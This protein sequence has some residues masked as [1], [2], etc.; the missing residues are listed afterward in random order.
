[1]QQNNLLNTG[2]KYCLQHQNIS[3]CVKLS[4]LCFKISINSSSESTVPSVSRPS[5]MSPE[6]YEWKRQKSLNSAHQYN[7]SI[8]FHKIQHIVSCFIRLQ[9]DLVIC[10]HTYSGREQLFLHGGSFLET[11]WDSQYIVS[12]IK[13]SRQPV[14]KLFKSFFS[15]LLLY[16]VF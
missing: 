11:L 14:Q 8:S 15:L 13:I 7:N 9:V 10:I 16:A 3:L 12:Y 5:T 2:V 6:N 4:I 1:M